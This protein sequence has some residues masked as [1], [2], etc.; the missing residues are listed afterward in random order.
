M[1]ERQTEVYYDQ[2]LKELIFDT[3]NGRERVKLAK[4][5]EW[6]VKG[7]GMHHMI[8]A[9]ALHFGASFEEQTMYSIVGALQDVESSENIS[10]GGKASW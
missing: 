2:T 6:K 8:R 5:M 3:S 1:A 10:F 4:L 9:L 7:K